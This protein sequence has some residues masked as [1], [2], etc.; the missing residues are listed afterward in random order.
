[1]LRNAVAAMYAAK[2]RTRGTY[3]F[4]ERAMNDVVRRNLALEGELR[5]A[6]E[7]KDLHVHYQPKVELKTNRITSVEALVRWTH[8]RLGPVSPADFVPVAEQAGLIVALG[9]FVMREACQQ[10]CEWRDAGF[11]GLRVSVNLSA[12]QLRT[13]EIT[14][15][16]SN[17]LEET[18]LEP[19]LLEVEITETLMIE[20]KGV[21]IAA[22][23]QLK[24]VGVTVSLDDFGTGY[25]SLSYLNS[26]PI[27]T[28]KI[29]R[30]FVKAIGTDPSNAAITAAIISMAHILG[31]N[32]VAE[33]VE[34]EEQR[35]FLLERGCDEM[36]GYLFSPALPPDELT[37]LLRDHQPY[38]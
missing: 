18:G 19:H 4:Y 7:R 37:A 20:N 26:F 10:A 34:T 12:Q 29:D 6:L 14:F 16:V 33:G 11:E 2:E 25:S 27:D 24:G 35:A 28:V 1:M 36:Q 3:Q 32:V 30:A 23:Q 22:L 9:E 13:E 31:L 38:S 15:T 21:A 17:I 5:A 8:P